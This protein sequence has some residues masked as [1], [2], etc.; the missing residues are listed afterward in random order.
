MEYDEKVFN[1]VLNQISSRE[2]A[3]LAL[4]TIASSASLVLL[5]LVLNDFI[6]IVNNE[7]LWWISILGI[8]FPLL[9]LAHNEI[10]RLTIHT[11]QQEWIRKQTG[12]SEILRL[13]KGRTA[14]IILSNIVLFIPVIGWVV[15]LSIEYAKESAW[16][17]I[18]VGL[19]IISPTIF[20]LT[21]LGSLK[22]CS[23]ESYRG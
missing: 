11:R 7:N 16:L 19:G 3:N 2:T 9:S 8:L 18:M 21:Q 1:A 14:R 20:C 22:L 17:Y 12:D 5:G 4:A 13:A 15:M 23:N 10:T 6:K